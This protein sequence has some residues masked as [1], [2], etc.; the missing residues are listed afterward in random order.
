MIK[1]GD[2]VRSNGRIATQQDG[3]RR[4]IEFE[5]ALVLETHG[6]Q[7]TVNPMGKN[8]ILIAHIDD[9]HVATAATAEIQT[10]GEL[11]L[12]GVTSMP[13]DP[14]QE[15]DTPPEVVKRTRPKLSGL[16]SSGKVVDEPSP[17]S[18]AKPTPKRRT[19]PARRHKPS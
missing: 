14:F 16:H 2:I 13:P 17:P 8:A 6:Q 10:A 9:L 19:P 11:S 1:Q 4:Y 18:A 12:S 3:K 15:P 5:A 7:I